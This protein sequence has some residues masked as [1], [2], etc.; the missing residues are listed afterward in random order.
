MIKW[1]RF[2]T[3]NEFNISIDNSGDE[4][5]N[6]TFSLLKK[7]QDIVN[8]APVFCD[9]FKTLSNQLIIYYLLTGYPFLVTLHGPHCVRSVLLLSIFVYGPGNQLI[10]R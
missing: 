8:M 2:D 6:S 10:N 9:C 5:I 4:L 7:S 3:I 1:N